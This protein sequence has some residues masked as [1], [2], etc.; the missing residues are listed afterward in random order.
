MEVQQLDAAIFETVRAQ[1]TA[2]ASAARD[3]EEAK[4]SITELFTKIKDIKGKAETSEEMVQDI[5]VDIR[6][7]DVAKRHLLFTITVLKR[8]QML[9][10]AVD[11]L[12]A[13]SSAGQ[14]ENS[15]HLLQVRVKGVCRSACL[16][17]SVSA[18]L[19]RSSSL[20]LSLSFI[21]SLSFFLS[22]LTTGGCGV[23]GCVPT[24]HELSRVL[25]SPESQGTHGHRRPR[26]VTAAGPHRAGV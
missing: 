13:N 12:Q 5:C 11:R 22:A 4:A 8:L 16:C 2:G 17:H 9:V 23:A 26:Q 25:Q 24:V 14:Y 20:S 10:T 7:L 18:S 3:L 15:G 21:L 6:Q 1:S 19:S